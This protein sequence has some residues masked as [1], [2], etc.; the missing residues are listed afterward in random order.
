MQHFLYSVLHCIVNIYIEGWNFILFGYCAG[1][2][3]VLVVIL[4]AK[5]YHQ[6]MEANAWNVSDMSNHEL[7]RLYCLGY[8]ISE[9]LA[10][11]CTRKHCDIQKKGLSFLNS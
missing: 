3:L 4:M 2:C 9:S 1:A 8:D 10:E 5:A 11:F 7:K 6:G